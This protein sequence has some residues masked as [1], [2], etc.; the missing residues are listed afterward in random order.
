MH[1][2]RSLDI[3][4]EDTVLFTDR[5]ILGEKRTGLSCAETSD[6]VLVSAKALRCGSIREQILGKQRDILYF[7]GAKVVVDD[8]PD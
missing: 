3:Q 1:P 8:V 2:F 4:I 7:V 6:I 5:C